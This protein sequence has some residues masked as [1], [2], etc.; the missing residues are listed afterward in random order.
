MLRFIAKRLAIAIPMLFVIATLTFLVVQLLPGDAAATILGENAPA[1]ELARVRHE[2]GLD[3]PIY[4]QYFS[5]LGG[6]LSGNFGHSLINGQSVAAA[7]GSRSVITMTIAVVA[8]V[9]SL[10]IGVLL[11][12]WAALRGGAVD[13]VLRGITSVGMSIPNFWIGVLFV[14]VF[15]VWLRVL[16]ANGWTDFSLDP[17]AWARGLVLPVAAISISAVATL[18][19]QTRASFHETL[20]RDFVRSLRASGLSVRSIALKHVLRNAS[21]PVITVVGLLFVSLLGGAVIVEQVFALPGVG[22][23]A[24][25]AVVNRDVPVI[26]GV[27]L[28]MT[29]VVLLVNLALDIAYAW[30]N[31]KVRMS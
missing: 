8:T 20:G 15:A 21:I 13:R 24:I 19:R 12:M 22:Q 2:L 11:G 29:L 4:V 14:L 28:Y 7:L 1:T 26:Q 17:G 3:Q 16:P 18:T 6:V 27:I 31:P 10:V 9:V 25:E 5:W 23:L 30:L